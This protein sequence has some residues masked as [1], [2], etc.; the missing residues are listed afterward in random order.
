MCQLSNFLISPLN[1]FNELY[2]KLNPDHSVF[3]AALIVVTRPE[4]L[5]TQD[6][7]GR[8]IGNSGGFVRICITSAANLHTVDGGLRQGKLLL[9]RD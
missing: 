3:E 6:F 8:K 4:N 9:K 5:V 1:Y 2:K 7:G